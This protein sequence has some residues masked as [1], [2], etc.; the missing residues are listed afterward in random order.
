MNK[1]I[2]SSDE[3]LFHITP[4]G[5]PV[6]YIKRK[7]MKTFYFY[8]LVNYGSQELEYIDSK[9]NRHHKITP[10]T[11]HFLEHKIFESKDKST[12]E[13]F[14][15]QSAS[16]NA[17]T[18]FSSTVYYFYCTSQIKENIG[19]M[20]RLITDTYINNETVEKEKGIITQEIKMYYDNP[21]WRTF[22]NFLNSLYKKNTVKYDVAGS[23]K[24]V[25]SITPEEL[26]RVY[27]D[28]YTSDNMTVFA[29]GDMD[30]KQLFTAM[31]EAPA[32]GRGKELRRI[33]PDEDRTVGRAFFTESMSIGERLFAMGFKEVPFG[34]ENDGMKKELIYKIIMDSVIGPV[35]RLYDELYEK[36][37]IDASFGYGLSSGLNF[38]YSLASGS[39][40]EPE[41]V[42]DAF[43]KEIDTLKSKG[44][45]KKQ[46]D[47][48]KRML[49]GE[50]IRLSDNDESFIKTIISLY[51]KKQDWFAMPEVLET[52]SLEEANRTL[53]N[54]MKEDSFSLAVT[55]PLKQ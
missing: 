35:S 6:R 32:A 29:L 25:E 42:R 36:A 13:T 43:F 38:T 54:V 33:Y 1:S 10:G 15:R 40:R 49:L 20:M 23:I 14:S 12:F 45:E 47:S 31:D 27:G 41:G 2:K 22:N 46:F 3:T 18:G 30:E 48:I 50:S 19:L 8:V 51:N 24:D 26:L 37:L 9:E 21:G 55:V 4:S 44:M 52:I 53:E 34:G 16:V 5:M 28:F 7:G 11:A 17:Y 39:S